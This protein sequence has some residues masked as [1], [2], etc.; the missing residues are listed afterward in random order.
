M[1]DASSPDDRPTAFRASTVPSGR[2]G[3]PTQREG[4]PHVAFA[5][6]GRSQDSLTR[7]PLARGTSV[8]LAFGHGGPGLVLTAHSVLQ[9]FGVGRSIVGGRGSNG[10]AIGEATEAPG[11]SARTRP[12]SWSASRRPGEPEVPA[13]QIVSRATG[14]KA[15]ATSSVCA[16]PAPAP[17]A[18]SPVPRSSCVPDVV[19]RHG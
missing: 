2:C 6:R 17:R 5:A 9:A 15:N 13:S 10:V 4:P 16:V 8:P 14:L 11:S 1:H 7:P 3:K 12:S 18:G 19:V